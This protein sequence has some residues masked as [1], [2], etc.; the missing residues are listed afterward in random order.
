MNE[1]QDAETKYVCHTCI[2]DQFLADQVKTKW[3]P[4][5]CSY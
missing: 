1:I 3:N 5:A 2:G 4:T